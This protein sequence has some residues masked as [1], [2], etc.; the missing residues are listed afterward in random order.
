MEIRKAVL[1]IR[2]SSFDIEYNNRPR[3]SLDTWSRETGEYSVVT[4]TWLPV[5]MKS[6][7]LLDFLNDVFNGKEDRV[8]DLTIIFDKELTV[9]ITRPTFEVK[10]TVF[11][12]LIV[13]R[14]ESS[15]ISETVGL[16]KI[17]YLT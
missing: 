5:V 8:L 16:P 14:Y 17:E 15:N 10:D 2:D 12:S 13:M 1:N 11:G 4:S 3:I 7:E 6:N 9:K